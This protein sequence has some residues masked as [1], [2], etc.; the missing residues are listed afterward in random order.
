MQLGHFE[1]A[2]SLLESA[3]TRLPPDEPFRAVALVDLIGVFAY[4]GNAHEGERA[5]GAAKS[6]LR[7]LG[8]G[9]SHGWIEYA[10]G[11]FALCIG[12]LGR[13]R[14][15]FVQ[16]ASAGRGADNRLVVAN[17]LAGLAEIALVEGD[18]AA[19]RELVEETTS[20]IGTEPFAPPTHDIL[21][22]TM[23]AE[24]S[25]GSRTAWPL[26]A[27][28][29]ATARTE[30]DWALLTYCFMAAAALD[31]QEGS[32]QSAAGMIGCVQARLRESGLTL[33]P[34]YQRRWTDLIEECRHGLGPA[35][36]DQ[37][38]AAGA[39]VLEQE[40]AERI[41]AAAMMQG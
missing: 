4:T 16:G 29:C 41:A 37:R 10:E 40:A 11:E 6:F 19:L 27:Q 13:A 21:R 5:L 25:K 39:V 31:V 8:D 38:A 17:C 35:E 18:L 23:W 1:R 14:T 12:D 33:R 7:S 24:V 20:V 22:V 34:W 30:S 32:L 9:R 3:F 2:R 15:C 36:Y 28:A 26:V